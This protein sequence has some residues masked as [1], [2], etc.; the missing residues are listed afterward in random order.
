MSQTSAPSELPVVSTG[1]PVSKWCRRPGLSVLL[2]LVWLALVHSLVPVHLLS[3][4]VIGLVV[5][6]WVDRFLP[7]PERVRWTVA[8]RLAWVV[9]WDIVAANWVVARLVLGPLARMQPV[10]LRVPL[11]CEHARV[12]ALFAT[13][14]TS[15]PGTVSCVVDEAARCIWVHALNGGDEAA[16]VTAMKTRY[17]TPLMALFEV[18]S[19]RTDHGCA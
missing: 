16:M 5:P 13:I 8:I 2:G 18:D 6:R 3:A 4:V 15:T 19:E 10:W 1:A 17:E 11:A 12:N 9:L 14:I 7:P